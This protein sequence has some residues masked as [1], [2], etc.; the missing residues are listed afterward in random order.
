MGRKYEATCRDCGNTFQASDGGGFHFFEL[1]CWVC[2]QVKTVIHE[3]IPTAT[4]QYHQTIRDAAKATGHSIEDLSS[5][6]DAM[7]RDALTRLAESLQI[8]STR[9]SSR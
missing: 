6:A 1:H 3:L 2:G 9:P 8:A 5:G 7:D 4:E